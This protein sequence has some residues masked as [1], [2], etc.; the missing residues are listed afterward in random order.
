MI[1]AAIIP[2][3]N[4]REVK[5]AP[6]QSPFIHKSE[7][8]IADTSKTVYQTFLKAEQTIPEDLLFQD[9]LFNETCEMIQDK[10]KAKVIQNIARLIDSSIALTKP[11][12]QPNYTIRFK[13]TAFTE[14]QLKK[15]QP[16]I[17]SFSEVSLF[18][19]IYYMYFPF[20]T[21]EVKCGAAALDVTDQQNAHSMTLVVRGI[22]ELFRLVKRE[23][24]LHR[25]ILAFSISHDH[26]TGGRNGG[27]GR[28]PVIDGEKTTY[29]HPIQEFSFTSEEGKDKW[30]SYKFTKNIYDIWMP[31]HLKRIFSVINELP[32]DLNF[33]VSQQ[34]EP[35][36]S[37]LSQE[38]ADSQSSHA[39]DVT[40]DTS[41]SQRIEGGAFKKPRKRGRPVELHAYSV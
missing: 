13:R 7:L 2:N 37:G 15:I 4:P 5:S 12:P 32:P 6:Y 31:T 23:K 3:F 14:D 33:K 21:C 35:G 8:G 34:S 27:V 18:I 39:G 17:S 24:E 10:N 41:M 38:E 29:R 25:E 26:R 1:A 9:N 20:L 22:V 16:F 30:T 40:P 19:G 36:E 11:H 28:Y